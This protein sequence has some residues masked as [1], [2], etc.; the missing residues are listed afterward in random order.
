MLDND[1]GFRTVMG[2]L[3]SENYQLLTNIEESKELIEFS[4]TNRDGIA[5]I[6]MDMITG[7]RF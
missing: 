2:I 6:T 5:G 3:S 4:D 7:L 1:E